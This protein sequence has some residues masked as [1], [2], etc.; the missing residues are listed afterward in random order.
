MVSRIEVR[1]D[2]LIIILRPTDPSAEPETLSVP[3][4]RPPFKR[5]RKILL[6]RG[7]VR[8]DVRPDRAERRI[9]LVKAIACG[10]GWLKEIISGSVIDAEQL[11]KRE[12]C[13]VGEREC[14]VDLT[15]LI[16]QRQS[17][18]SSVLALNHGKVN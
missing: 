6:P 16:T 12:R 4:Q 8:K 11:A 18:C 7:T 13:S 14:Q 1:R 15:F 9:R 2:R 5:F 3:W 10:R 17:R